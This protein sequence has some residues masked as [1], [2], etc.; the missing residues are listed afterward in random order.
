[1]VWSTIKPFVSSST[2]RKPSPLTC[3]MPRIAR[4]R[5]FCA[6][7]INKN[8]I[9][10][11]WI[12][13]VDGQDVTRSTFNASS[14]M[15]MPRDSNTSTQPKY[16]TGN[17]QVAERTA[18]ASDCHW[19][20]FDDSGTRSFRRRNESRNERRKRSIL[21]GERLLNRNDADFCWRRIEKQ[22]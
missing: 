11:M 10:N 9:R 12:K 20:G 2:T 6:E 22:N 14:Q 8:K 4:L 3:K 15:C 7:R 16:L 17:E 1:M 19:C 13:R 21:F 18:S 5:E